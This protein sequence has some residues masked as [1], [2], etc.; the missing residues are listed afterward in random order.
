MAKVLGARGRR[1]A[2]RIRCLGEG[3]LDEFRHRIDGRTHTQIDNAARMTL[4]EAFGRAEG[5]PREI[6]VASRY[7]SCSCGGRA[8]TSGTSWG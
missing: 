6:R 1:V 7:S 2:R 4:G 5:V 3:P 8:A